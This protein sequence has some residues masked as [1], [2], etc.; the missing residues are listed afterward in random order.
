MRRFHLL[1]ADKTHHISFTLDEDLGCPAF[2]L[3]AIA[4]LRII[5]AAYESSLA[6][7]TDESEQMSAVLESALWPYIKQC[8]DL[9]ATLEPLSRCIILSNCYDLSQVTHRSCVLTNR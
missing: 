4:D 3:D 2:F 5:L 9:S 8:E 7:I 6:P 1:M